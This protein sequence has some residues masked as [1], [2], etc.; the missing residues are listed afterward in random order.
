MKTDVK[1]IG[2][3]L[4]ILREY[5]GLSRMEFGKLFQ[6]KES[7][8]YQWEHG[9]CIPRLVKLMN[10]SVHFGVSLDC[11][12]HGKAA[13]DNVLEKQMC[14]TEAKP[15]LTYNANGITAQ[16]NALPAR[17]RERLIGYLDAL[18]REN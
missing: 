14:K 1:I 16:L 5:S 8:V 18:T 4:N 13:N 15:A 12:L 9:Y 17:H 11:I 3:R 6:S 10:I 7:T 2:K